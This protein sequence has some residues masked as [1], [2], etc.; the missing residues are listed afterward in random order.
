M[1]NVDMDFAAKVLGLKQWHR[2]PVNDR[3]RIALRVITDAH[4][5]D[6]TDGKMKPDIALHNAVAWI[7]KAYEDGKLAGIRLERGEWHRK[8]RKMFDLPEV[9]RG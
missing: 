2:E 3:E 7:D 1:I 4:R 5:P 8:L 6:S 9:P